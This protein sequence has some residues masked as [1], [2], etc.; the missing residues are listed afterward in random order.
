MKEKE[1]CK[2]ADIRKYSLSGNFEI[3]WFLC[4]PMLFSHFY[5]LEFDLK[6]ADWALASYFLIMDTSWLENRTAH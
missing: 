3:V 5:R 4:Q 2:I 1:R 6:T